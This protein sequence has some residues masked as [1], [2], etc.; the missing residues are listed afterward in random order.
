[1]YREDGLAEDLNLDKNMKWKC[2]IYLKRLKN[3][4][5]VFEYLSKGSFLIGFSDFPSVPSVKKKRFRSF[6]DSYIR[7][8]SCY[9][10]LLTFSDLPLID[11]F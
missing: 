1:M 11:C 10:W 9:F 8:A 5:F 6:H 2:V 4:R 3:F 7:A